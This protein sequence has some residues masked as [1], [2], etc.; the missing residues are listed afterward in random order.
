MSKLTWRSL[1]NTLHSLSEAEVL[2]LLE[3]ELKNERRLSILRRLHQR[4][5]A[6]RAD[7]ERIEI[8]TKAEKI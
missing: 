6:L 1:N 7:R 8:L 4:Y 3:E 5:T 2:A